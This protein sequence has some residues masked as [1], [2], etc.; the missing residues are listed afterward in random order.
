MVLFVH[1]NDAKRF[2][3]HD[4]QTVTLQNERG[5]ADFTVEISDRTAPG[6]VVSEG[7]W[8]RERIKGAH[9]VNVLTSQ[10]LT[11]EG[12]GSTFYDVRVDIKK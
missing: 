3:L 2:D 10:R 8:W 12:A 7:V 6:H 9:S 4:G 5:E 11:D 1:P